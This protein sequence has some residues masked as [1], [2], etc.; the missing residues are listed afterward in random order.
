MKNLVIVCGLLI[1]SAALAAKKE[2]A[3]TPDTSDGGC[4]S[5]DGSFSYRLDMRGVSLIFGKGKAARKMSADFVRTQPSHLWMAKDGSYLETFT[6]KPMK[7]ISE[8]IPDEDTDNVEM[9][10]GYD[11]KTGRTFAGP[12]KCEV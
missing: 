7:D 12:M 8:G 4:V 6:G 9:G 5:Q 3:R 2:G 1:C 10:R 11:A